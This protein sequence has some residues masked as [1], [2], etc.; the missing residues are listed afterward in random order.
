[1]LLREKWVS[2][3]S[4]KCSSH[5]RRQFHFT[6]IA[7]Y[8]FAYV[9]VCMYLETGTCFLRSIVG[10]V[11]NPEQ[12]V[13]DRLTAVEGQNFVCNQMTM[14]RGWCVWWMWVV[15]D[16]LWTLT[17]MMHLRMGNIRVWISVMVM[18]SFS[19]ETVQTIYT[20][21]FY[22]PTII[23]K[24]LWRCCCVSICDFVLCSQM[25]TFIVVL[26]VVLRTTGLQVVQWRLLI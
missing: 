21:V 2:P 15:T 17:R 20:S 8:E 10:T 4:G 14:I 16:I 26:W 3:D 1:M 18:Q 9:Y 12:L 13:N 24:T 6:L 25:L 7:G 5:K 23:P 19:R 11:I 22:V